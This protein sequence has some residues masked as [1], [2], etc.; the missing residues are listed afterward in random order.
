MGAGQYYCTI[1]CCIRVMHLGLKLY[2]Y[3]ER[4]EGIK[5]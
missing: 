2:M 5:S 3:V 4:D 1:Y